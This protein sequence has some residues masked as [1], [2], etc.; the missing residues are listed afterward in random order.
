MPRPARCGNLNRWTHQGK[1]Y[2]IVAWNME[3]GGTSA[4]VM[5]DPVTGKPLFPLPPEAG[6]GGVHLPM[7]AGDY[8]VGCPS[9]MADNGCVKLSPTGAKT[10]WKVPANGETGYAMTAAHTFIA[11]GGGTHVYDNETGKK[12][13]TLPAAG[14]RTNHLFSSDGRLF[15]QPEGRHSGQSFFMMDITDPAKGAVR[16]GEWKPPHPTT[17][18]YATMPIGYPVVD[19]RLF[20]RGNAG[21]YCYDLRKVA[22]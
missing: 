16:G 11:D 7:V 18:A 15:L 20:V 5:I 19:G 21:I 4:G 9:Y 22:R 14:A 2:L 10:L 1:E 12:L 13:I 3:K 8:L 6:M 17:T